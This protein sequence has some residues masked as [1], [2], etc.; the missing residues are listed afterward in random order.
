MAEIKPLEREM[1]HDLGFKCM[2]QCEVEVWGNI[3]IPFWVHY[4]EGFALKN[5]AFDMYHMS[6]Y[7]SR[8]EF[9]DAFLNAYAESIMASAEIHWN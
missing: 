3:D 1:L 8:K 2:E 9:F 4:V 6:A 7:T 5:P